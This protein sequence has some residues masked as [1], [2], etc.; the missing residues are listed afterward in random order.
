MPGQGSSSSSGVGGGS[1]SGSSGMLQAPQSLG[2]SFQP[3]ECESSPRHS[4]GLGGRRATAGPSSTGSGSGSGG[5]GSS[6]PASSAP[7][8]IDGG[9]LIQSS[10]GSY[11]SLILPSI[12]H[13]PAAMMGS[14]M[15]GI[16]HHHHQQPSFYNYAGY[17]SG[18]EGGHRQV[19][20]PSQVVVAGG[21]QRA[22][23]ER[24]DSPM[25]GVCV[26]QSPVA[27]H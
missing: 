14:P 2:G 17:G 16:H 19:V 11:N 9:S 20:V 25:V 7:A 15:A 10:L 12:P 4:L 21:K 18:P 23:A 6:A 5:G 1:G 26:Q 24:E 22:D 13:L 27:I 3:M 8:S